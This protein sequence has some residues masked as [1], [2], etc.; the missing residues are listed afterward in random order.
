[1][2]SIQRLYVQDIWEL[3]SVNGRRLSE[4]TWCRA[5]QMNEYSVRFYLPLW[6]L[7][8]YSDDED[9]SFTVTP[10]GADFLCTA[11]GFGKVL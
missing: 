7:I 4:L 6:L 8:L 11:S 3:N 2:H 1:M 9:Y 5:E 10:C